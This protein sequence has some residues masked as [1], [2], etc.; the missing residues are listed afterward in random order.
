VE[1]LPPE[2]RPQWVRVDRLLGEHGLQQDT[3]AARQ[4]FELR[5][6]ARR[7]EPG[8]EPGFKAL[9]RWYL[10]SE[11]FKNQ[12]LEQIDGKLGEHH[13]GQLRR[14]SADAKA[15]RLISEELHRLGW[16]EAEL[17]SR[18]KS[19]PI[20]LAI[21]ARLRRETTLPIKS[22]A[23]RLDLGTSKSAN[24]RLHTAMNSPMPERSVQACLGM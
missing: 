24:A 3:A 7:L 2:H 5:M 17:V 14:E 4:Q 19:D 22:I 10:G 16:N 20:K 21:E 1:Q 11:H 23:A 15:E 12:L 8:D 6:E 13:S 9:R 18:R